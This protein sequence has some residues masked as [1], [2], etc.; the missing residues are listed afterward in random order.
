[1]KT[2]LQEF[3]CSL[4]PISGHLRL[5]GGSL[6]CLMLASCGAPHNDSALELVYQGQQQDEKVLSGQNTVLLLEMRK[7]SEDPPTREK[8]GFWLPRMH[9]ADSLAQAA[10]LQLA[11]IQRYDSSE[12]SSHTA[13]VAA[14]L[15]GLLDTL[16]GTFFKQDTLARNEFNAIDFL[17]ARFG[18]KAAVPPDLA[19]LLAGKTNLE[20]ALFLAQLRLNILSLTNRLLSFETEQVGT[21]FD[22]YYSYSALVGQ[23]TNVLLPGEKLTINAGVGAFLATAKPL[24]TMAGKVVEQGPDGQAVLQFKVPK[25]PGRYQVPVTIR[26]ADPDGHEQQVT[27]WVEYRVVPKPCFE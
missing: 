1:M 19:A 12:G 6:L 24:F 13:G 9:Y 21:L 15:L 25:K 7:K 14:R 2:M 20:R 17:R 16:S 5:L 26:F 11:E 10:L 3:T 22:G 23:N 8:A 4:T 18:A 27:K